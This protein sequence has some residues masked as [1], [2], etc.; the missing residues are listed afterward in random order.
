MA[1]IAGTPARPARPSIPVVDRGRGA[2]LG[3][4]R[5]AAI[6]LVVL[7]H[8][9][10]GPDAPAF[11]AASEAER[12]FAAVAFRLAT[13]LAVPIF[14]LLAFMSL[15]PR[16]SGQ[17]DTSAIIA[18]RFRRLAPA[19]L[20]WTVVYGALKI[21]SGG[22]HGPER[23]AEYVLLGA[24]AAHM[25]FL[26]LLLALTA[27]LPLW[28]ALARRPW[29]GLAACVAL[30]LGASYALDLSGTTGP[31]SQAALGLLGSA[32]YALAALTLVEWW[33]AWEPPERW[34]RPTLVLASGL[35]LVAGAA[36]TGQAVAEA[37]AAASLPAP[38]LVRVAR[39]AFPIAVTCALL[40]SRARLPPQTIGLGPLVFGVYL[41]HP[42]V[43]KLALAPLTRIP[44]LA[45]HQVALGPLVAPIV[46][47][48]SLCL[49]L[50]LMGTPLRR[51]LA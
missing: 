41:V 51:V 46:L 4:L 12:L 27:L 29:L 25:Y 36:L 13:A 49:V 32:V 42:F 39:V 6:G 35:A 11:A 23:I 43:A 9:T 47:A 31:W 19:Y 18:S 50:L 20:F 14:L 33:G 44:L 1:P 16:T 38:L 10:A 34:R 40:S 21:A 15:H 17:R 24:S 26:P 22:G 45:A 5:M 48:A 3:T 30:P 2:R 28:L 37:A 7:V 8:T